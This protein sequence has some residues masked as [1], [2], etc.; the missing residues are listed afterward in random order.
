MVDRECHHLQDERKTDYSRL[1]VFF[2]CTSSNMF[3][4]VF[5]QPGKASSPFAAPH[6]GNSAGL[7]LPN[8]K[9]CFNLFQGPQLRDIRPE[10]FNPFGS[11]VRK[12]S[13]DD[14]P[15]LK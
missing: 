2:F 12:T 5:N 4:F 7:R 1:P 9:P 11:P 3:P 6:H 15:P 14:N 10:L 8:L 13:S